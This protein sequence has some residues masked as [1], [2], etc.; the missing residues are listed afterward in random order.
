MNISLNLSAISPL[1]RV[2]M[3]TEFVFDVALRCPIPD[4]G[5]GDA[6]GCGFSS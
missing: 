6:I 4:R 2:G 1:P 5:K 3:E